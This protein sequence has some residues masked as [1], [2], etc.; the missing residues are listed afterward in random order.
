MRFRGRRQQR[1]GLVTALVVLG[2]ALVFAASAAAEVRTGSATDGTEPERIPGS[3]DIVAVSASFDTGGSLSG[4]VTTLAAQAVAVAETA[5]DVGSGATVH[6][7]ARGSSRE[8]DGC[9]TRPASRVRDA[10]NFTLPCVLTN[11]HGRVPEFDPPMAW[12]NSG[13][14]IRALSSGPETDGR[15]AEG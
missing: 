10:G 14:H 13:T 6:A 1:F 9:V 3:I 7:S 8:G 4:A 15:R 2:L 5:G 11:S 12:S